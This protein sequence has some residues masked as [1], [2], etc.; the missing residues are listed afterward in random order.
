MTH[1]QALNVILSHICHSGNVDPCSDVEVFK[2][3][4]HCN[5]VTILAKLVSSDKDNP[6]VEERYKYE[7]VKVTVE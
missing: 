7:I 4:A 2:L 5:N 1:E 3:E 6:I